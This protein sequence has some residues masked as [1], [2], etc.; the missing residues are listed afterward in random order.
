VGRGIEHWHVRLTPIERQ[1]EH[2]SVRRRKDPLIEKYLAGGR[3]VFR[4]RREGLLE[5]LPFV[6]GAVCIDGEQL[7]GVAR[8]ELKKMDRPSRDQSG[9]MSWDALNVTFEV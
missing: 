7:R 5:D 1:C 6:S 8:S 3:Y 4:N 2:V 9:N